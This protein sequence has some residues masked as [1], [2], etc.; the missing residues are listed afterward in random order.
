M[1]LVAGNARRI[2]N[3]QI[4]IS[5]RISTEQNS[6]RSLHKI[7]QQG[8]KPWRSYSSVSAEETKKLLLDYPFALPPLWHQMDYTQPHSAS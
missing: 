5:Q 8:S 1:E 7:V 6:V 2:I 3:L 4:Y